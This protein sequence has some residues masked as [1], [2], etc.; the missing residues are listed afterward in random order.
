MCTDTLT[1]DAASVDC[2][3][4]KNMKDLIK[5]GNDLLKAKVARV[6]INTGEYEPK[7]GGGTNEAALKELAEKISME[8]KLRKKNGSK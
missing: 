7:E 5:I 8:R 4:D 3:T 1:R 2:S 6:N